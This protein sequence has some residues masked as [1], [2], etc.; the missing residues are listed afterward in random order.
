MD[1]Q[2]TQ[3]VSHSPLKQTYL[4]FAGFSTL[5]GFIQ[6]QASTNALSKLFWALLFICGLGMT[7][8]SVSQCINE[9]YQFNTLT[10]SRILTSRT[11]AFPAISICNANRIQ[12]QNLYDLTKTC[13]EVSGISRQQQYDNTVGKLRPNT[14]C[15]LTTLF[16]R[17]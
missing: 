12:C 7:A 10:S 16:P 1:F 17:I 8:F 15:P 2:K 11:R 14:L 4:W 6:F 3:G 5:N 9:Y 13:E